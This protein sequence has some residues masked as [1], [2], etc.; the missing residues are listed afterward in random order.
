M[1]EAVVRIQMLGY[2]FGVGYE[3]SISKCLGRSVSLGNE[4]VLMRQI[5]IEL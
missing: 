4:R 5:N 3:F 1:T 2:A